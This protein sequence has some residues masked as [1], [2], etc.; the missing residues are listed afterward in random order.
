MV[1]QGLESFSFADVHHAEADRKTGEFE[2]VDIPSGSYKI[3]DAYRDGE[4]EFLGVTQV[5]VMD[6]D[7]NAVRIVITR[8][9]EIHGRVI[10]EGKISPSSVVH[11]SASNRDREAIG[12]SDNGAAKPDGTFLITGLRDG[13]FDISAF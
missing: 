5:E 3:A 10:K 9:A 1:P 4:N 13:V 12:G 7:V 11:V 8:G 6:A 2:L